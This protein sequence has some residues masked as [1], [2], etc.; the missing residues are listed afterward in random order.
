VKFRLVL[1]LVGD[2]HR[3]Q[4]PTGCRT[5][6]RCYRM[7]RF[8]V[9][10]V[11]LRDEN[12][13]PRVSGSRRDENHAQKPF[14]HI[15]H[16]AVFRPSARWEKCYSGTWAISRAK[17][18]MMGVEQPAAQ[19]SGQSC[20]RPLRARVGS[21]CPRNVP[22]ICWRRCGPWD[23][24]VVEEAVLL[25]FAFAEEARKNQRRGQFTALFPSSMDEKRPLERCLGELSLIN[26]FFGDDLFLDRTQANK[27]GR[28]QSP[29]G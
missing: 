9:G 1:V 25:V 13:T 29:S 3:L 21:A 8:A 20:P 15:E 18:S 22:C 26:H 12:K 23:D 14:R 11:V 17:G 7:P 10:C 16:G 2:D 27:T 28:L 24:L 19:G 6:G 4:R 5:S